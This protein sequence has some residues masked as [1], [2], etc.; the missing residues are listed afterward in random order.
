MSTIQDYRRTDLR[1]NVSGEPFWIVS[2]VVDGHE[3]S[4]L[5]DKACVLFSFPD[6]GKQIIIREIAVHVMR[7]FTTGTTLELG[8]FTLTS[9]GLSTNDTATEVDDNGFVEYTDIQPE[10]VGWYYPSKGGFV[11][12]RG[13][14]MISD[15]ENLII[16][17]STNVPA[18]VLSPKVATI[19]TGQVQVAM[20]VTY[21]PGS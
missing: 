8:L 1:T 11:D 6:A 2:K 13:A 5:K 16:G 14:G 3:Q 10:V 7:A 18:I 21:V 12:V 17:A 15:G 19:I 20:Y 4:G 9:D